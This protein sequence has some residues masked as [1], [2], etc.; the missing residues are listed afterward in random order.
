ML[1]GIIS[2]GGVMMPATRSASASCILIRMRKH[3]QPWQQHHEQQIECTQTYAD[4]IHGA[5]QTGFSQTR[6]AGQNKI[7]PKWLGMG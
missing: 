6:Q 4:Q 3:V 7:E 1:V 2:R 5:K